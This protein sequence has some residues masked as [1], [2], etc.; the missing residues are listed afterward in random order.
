VVVSL[1]HAAALL[2]RSVRDRYVV[3]RVRLFEPL[4]VAPTLEAAVVNRPEVEPLS[5]QAFLRAGTYA[6]KPRLAL[7]RAA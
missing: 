7:E 6:A 3:P 4:G 5:M 1:R 2:P